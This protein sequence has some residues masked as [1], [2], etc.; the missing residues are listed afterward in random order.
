MP[1]MNTWGWPGIGF[2]TCPANASIADRRFLF[3]DFL[4]RARQDAVRH[5]REDPRAG[6]HTPSLTHNLPRAVGHDCISALERG[7]WINGCER[8]FGHR[9]PCPELGHSR[10][11]C[12]RQLAFE[13]RQSLAQHLQVWARIAGFKTGDGCFEATGVPLQ[14]PLHRLRQTPCDLVHA[15][16]ML[17]DPAPGV[18]QPACNAFQ[19]P[20]K[21]YRWERA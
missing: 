16:L 12:E 17:L 9:Q 2:I 14:R 5:A 20:L 1:C 4:Y 18:H 3:L 8:L 6:L 15:L 21:V 13:L 10:T 7:E 19:P 11:E